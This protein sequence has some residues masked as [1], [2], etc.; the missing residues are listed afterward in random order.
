MLKDSRR[1]LNTSPKEKVVTKQL[2][3]PKQ[4]KEAGTHKVLWASEND[5]VLI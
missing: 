2:Y 3:Q 4:N 1:L 5:K